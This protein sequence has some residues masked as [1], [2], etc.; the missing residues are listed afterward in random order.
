MLI[1]GR[2]QGI[3][4]RPDEPDY[5]DDLI[6]LLCEVHLRRTLELSDGDPI[7]FALVS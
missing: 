5:P 3:V 7:S 6:E 4:A 1:A 2:Y